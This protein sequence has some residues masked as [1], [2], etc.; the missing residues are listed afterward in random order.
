MGNAQRGSQGPTPFPQRGCVA[1]RRRPGKGAGASGVVE[2]LSG[3]VVN[4]PIDPVVNPKLCS[5]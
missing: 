4:G 2:G 3:P 1:Q 5:G